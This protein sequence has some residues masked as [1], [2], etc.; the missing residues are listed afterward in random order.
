M[1]F[2]SGEQR[3]FWRTGNI[4][5]QDF[6]FRE[7]GHF[8]RGIF[9]FTTEKLLDGLPERTETC[10]TDAFEMTLVTD[11]HIVYEVNLCVKLIRYPKYGISP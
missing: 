10:C 2:F 8:F 1:A 9:F 5:N 4:E 6:V 3:Q 7:Q 11:L